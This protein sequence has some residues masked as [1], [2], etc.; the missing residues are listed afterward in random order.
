MRRATHS[1]SAFDSATF[2]T[3]LFY[4]ALLGFVLLSIFFTPL[5][6]VLAD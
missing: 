5:I 3:V 4:A 1:H 2:H 6:Q